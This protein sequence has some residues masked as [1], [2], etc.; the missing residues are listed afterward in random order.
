MK[1]RFFVVG[2][3][4][5]VL[6][7]PICSAKQ[8]AASRELTL[9][10]CKGGLLARASLKEGQIASV[11]F[12]I[13]TLQN[14]LKSVEL[15]LTNMESGV[16]EVRQLSDETIRFKRVGIGIWSAC[17]SS[18]TVSIEKALI[19]ASY[20]SQSMLLAAV[21]GGSA[22]LATA[23][24]LSGGG[25]EDGAPGGNITQAGSGLA[26]A[27]SSTVL[28]SSGSTPTSSARKPLF[29][30]IHALPR[31]MVRLRIDALPM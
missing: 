8:P 7:P 3:I 21:T 2:Y 6:C 1:I 23:L 12:E 29:Q 13:A 18:D 4:I 25:A 16:T 11:T 9:L 14:P 20:G 17:L 28:S 5:L 19:E 26:A 10:D 15:I 24:G 27:P 22:A 30:S 31:P